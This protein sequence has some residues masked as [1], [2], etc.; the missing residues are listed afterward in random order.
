M[1]PGRYVGTEAQEEDP[2]AFEEKMR[3]LTAELASQFKESTE[4]EREVERNLKTLGYE[5]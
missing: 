5:I 1:T 4:L 3:R 2:E